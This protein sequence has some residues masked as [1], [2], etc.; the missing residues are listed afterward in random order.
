M[1]EIDCIF[2]KIIN[3][4]TKSNIILENNLCIAIYDLHPA[5][6]IHILIIPKKH[7]VNINN[8]SY[9][10][11]ELCHSMF[12]LAKSLAVSFNISEKGY[13]LV[14][15]NQKGAGQSVFHL[16]MH[17]LAGRDFSWPPG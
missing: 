7:L 13:R 11:L 12:L 3:K 8:I 1:S 14:I 2:C 17:F 4:S 10:D 6:Q 16:H 5:A 15:N 9:E